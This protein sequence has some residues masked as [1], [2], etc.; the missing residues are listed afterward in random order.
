MQLLSQDENIQPSPELIPNYMYH[1]LCRVAD[2]NGQIMTLPI[3]NYLQMSDVHV[4][5]HTFDY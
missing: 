4:V 2:I 1:N 3:Q 5:A